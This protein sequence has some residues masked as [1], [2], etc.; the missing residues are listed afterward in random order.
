MCLDGLSIL[1]LAWGSILQLSPCWQTC[2]GMPLLCSQRFCDIQES[3]ILSGPSPF[4][5][6]WLKSKTSFC[7]CTP[8]VAATNCH[9]CNDLKQQCILLQFRMTAVYNQSLWANVK[10]LEGLV[11]SGGSRGESASLHFQAFWR[12]FVFPGLWVFP[13]SP[14]SLLPS[15]HLLLSDFPACLFL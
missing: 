4:N 12:L 7:V 1:T 8:I 2:P 11:P 14:W 15:S 13:D 10:V 6:R 3:A 5:P 9:K